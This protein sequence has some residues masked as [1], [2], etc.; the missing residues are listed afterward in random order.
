MTP[1]WLLQGMPWAALMAVL[2]ACLLA[3]AL[4]T[5]PVAAPAPAGSAGDGDAPRNG[6][7][8]LARRCPQRLP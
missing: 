2:T 1:R 4:P 7:C 3:V 6:S 8:L 5:P